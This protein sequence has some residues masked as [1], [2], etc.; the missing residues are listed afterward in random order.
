MGDRALT[1][2]ELCTGTGYT[3]DDLDSMGDL[4]RT[5]P[6]ERNQPQK[7]TGV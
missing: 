3:M 7:V 1:I 5:M 4:H 6:Q 2:N